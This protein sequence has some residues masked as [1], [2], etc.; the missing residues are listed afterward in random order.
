V[1]LEKSSTL[2]NFQKHFL[3][4]GFFCFFILVFVFLFLGF[5]FFLFLQ[6]SGGVVENS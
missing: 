5:Y 2:K 6:A 3:G 4:F 1:G